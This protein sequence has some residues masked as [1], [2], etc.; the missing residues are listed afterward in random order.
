MNPP[1][2][3]RTELLQQWLS[4][5]AKDFEV[6]NHLLTESPRYYE[7]LAFHAQQAAEKYLK[8][9]LVHNQIAF[10]KNHDLEELLNLI[11]A[12]DHE[13]AEFLRDVIVLSDYAVGIR[14]PSDFHGL[15]LEEVQHALALARK[16]REAILGRL[17]P[18]PP[19]A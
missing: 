12:K 5:A 10:R 4:L 6:A 17:P 11:A 13:L 19:P 8:A 16:V 14:Y 9:F 18:L 7:I 15:T 1:E 2:E 3:V